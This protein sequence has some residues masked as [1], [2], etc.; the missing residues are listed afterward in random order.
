MLN[1]GRPILMFKPLNEQQLKSICDILAHT[2]NGLTKSELGHILDQCEIADVGDGSSSNGYTFKFGVNKRT[3]L[4][5]CFANEIKSKKSFNNIYLFIE[6]AMDPVGF[7]RQSKRE[8]Y[9]IMFEEI[10]KVLLFIG[11]E[12]GKDGKIRETVRAQSLEEVDRRVNNLKK[13][14]Y[15]RAIHPEVTKYCIK[16]YFDVVFE[17]AKGLA[18]RVRDLTGLNTDGSKLFQEA[19]AKNDPYI[20]LNGLQTESEINEHIGLRELLESIFHLVRNPAAHTPKINWH[21]EE[22]KA[23]DILTVISVAHKYLDHC[24]INPSKKI[25]NNSFS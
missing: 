8:Q 25:D 10:N 9:Q 22:N 16:D 7:V 14:L 15:D 19:F 23:L 13:R 21:V 20:L 12:L 17:A 11:L 18:Q 3:W 4:Y 6:K 1:A 5:N 24:F 2:Y